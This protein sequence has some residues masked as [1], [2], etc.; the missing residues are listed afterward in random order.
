MLTLRLIVTCTFL[1]VSSSLITPILAHNTKVITDNAVGGAFPSRTLTLLDNHTQ[2]GSIEAF[3]GSHKRMQANGVYA[4]SNSQI[5]SDAI[6]TFPNGDEGSP[7][8]HWQVH[9]EVTGGNGRDEDCGF[10][11]GVVNRGARDFTDPP[12]DTDSLST[13]SAEGYGNIYNQ[14]SQSANCNA[15]I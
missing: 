1:I 11:S 15:S 14:I 5:S 12:V 3:A 10:Y 9:A 7:Y 8:G 2:H 13:V 4:A 6:L